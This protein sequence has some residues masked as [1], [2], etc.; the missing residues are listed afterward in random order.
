MPKPIGQPVI[1]MVIYMVND[2]IRRK[3]IYDRAN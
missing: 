2:I 3:M 1:D